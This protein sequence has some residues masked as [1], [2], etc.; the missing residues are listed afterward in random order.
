MPQIRI[1]ENVENQVM[2]HAAIES[3]NLTN[4]SLVL[5]AEALKARERADMALTPKPK[6]SNRRDK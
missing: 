2:M 5:I 3:R 1:P 6:R 4:M